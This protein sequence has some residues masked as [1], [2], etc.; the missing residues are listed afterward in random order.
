[1]NASWLLRIRLHRSETVV[2]VVVLV[3]DVVLDEVVVVLGGV[4]VDVVGGSVVVVGGRVVVVGGSVV[5][6]GVLTVVVAVAT[7]LPAAVVSPSALTVALLVM[8][9]PSPVPAF[10]RT[11][12]MNTWGPSSEVRLG[13]LHDS[14]VVQVQPGGN[15]R[16]TKVVLAGTGSLSETLVAVVPATAFCTVIV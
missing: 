4:V 16:D 6:V 5:V 7:L 10:T 13:R 15:E 1:L 8:T 9:V 2:V 12:R 3:V 11:T 14:E